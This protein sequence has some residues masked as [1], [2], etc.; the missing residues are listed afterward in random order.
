LKNTTTTPNKNSLI[1][2][3]PGYESPEAMREAIHRA[4]RLTLTLIWE[5]FSRHWSGRFLN[6]GKP[7]PYFAKVVVWNPP[8][9]VNVRDIK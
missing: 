2:G 9:L 8:R 4:S 5:G 7:D 1:A 6:I 3:T